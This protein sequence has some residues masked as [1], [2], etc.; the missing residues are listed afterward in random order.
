MYALKNIKSFKG[1]EGEPCYQ[2]ALHGPAGKVGEWSDDSWGGAMR[3]DFVNKAEED[4]FVAWATT[5]LPTLKNFDGKPYDPSA[6]TV[7]D[8]IETAVS[9]MNCQIQE[10]KE[11]QA[12]AKKGIAYYLPDTRS[13]DGKT[14]YAVNAPFTPE[15]VAALRKRHPELL[16]IVNER[17]GLP[18]IDAA[19]YQQAEEDKRF[20]RMCKS[21]TLFTV[22]QPD[23]VVKTMQSKLPFSAALKASLQ[24]RYPN[25]VE[26]INERY[27]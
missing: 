17:L 16:E 1:H 5:Y 21:T 8:I 24:A 12:A 26:I 6:M 18:F 11:L 25:L 2:G 27:A 14:L 15:N 19:A 13:S 20:K 9:E 23:G 10:E 4:K 22:R 3:I 7:W